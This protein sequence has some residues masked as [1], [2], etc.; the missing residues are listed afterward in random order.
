MRLTIN[1]NAFF[2]SAYRHGK[3]SAV[4]SPYIR[5]SQTII[6]AIDIGNIHPIP[7]PVIDNGNE[8]DIGKIHS[9]DSNYTIFT[10]L[11]VEPIPPLPDRPL[12]YAMVWHPPRAATMYRK[13]DISQSLMRAIFGLGLKGI[14]FC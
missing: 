8:T 14:A 3:I 2:W 5:I 9:I 4:I 7:S 13:S 11:C 1:P 12:Y 10:T 6:H